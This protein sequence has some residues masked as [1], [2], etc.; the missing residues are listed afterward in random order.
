M[1]AGGGR[2][3]PAVTVAAPPTLVGRA[4]ALA[5]VTGAADAPPA[6]VVV[7]GEAGIGK[8]R[9]LA[10][11]LAARPDRT[12]LMLACPPLRDPFPLGP[13]IT[14]LH[15]F[16]QR[17]AELELTPLTG[18]LRP[19]FPDWA[20][21]LPPVPASLDSP[22]ATRHRI[23][24]ALSDLVERLGIEVLALEDAHWADS[25]TLEWLLTLT[26]GD[27]QPGDPVRGATGRALVVTYRPTDVPDGS[28]LPRLTSRSP[29]GW[30]QAVVE[31]A[32]LD[33]GQTRELVG[34]MLGAAEVSQ[35]LAAF[36][37]RHTDGLPLA[38]E[39]TVRFLRERQDLADAHGRWSRQALAQ[40]RVPPKLRDSV[41]ERVAQLE[42]DAEAVLRASAV[43]G[44]PADETLL[45]T[46]AGLDPEAGRRGI[47]RASRAGLLRDAGGG[48]LAFRHVLDAKAVEEAVPAPERW[49]LHARAARALRDLRPQPVVRLARH[50]REA[51][52]VEAWCRYAEAAA[53][54]AWESGDDHTATA[55]LMDLLGASRDL[56]ASGDGPPGPGSPPGSPP[57]A[58]PVARRARLALKLG[59]AAFFGAVALGEL[60]ERV[61]ASLR[62]VLAGDDLPAPERGEIQVQLGRMLWRVGQGRAAFAAFEAAVPDLAHRPD[63]A[64]R[65][66]SNLAVPGVPGWPVQRHLQWL[67]RA[68]E[69]ADRAG[70]RSARLALAVNR[71]TTLLLLGRE[72]GW[73]AIGELPGSATDPQEQ[74]LVASGLMNMAEGSMPWG[75]YRDTRRLLDRA[76]DFAG[77]INYQRFAETAQVLEAYLDWYTGAWTGLR[78]AAA[79]LA[80]VEAVEASYRLRAR[81]L[82]A[83]LD[84]AAGRRAA[85]EELRLVATEYARWGL[86]EPEMGLAPA[87]W[88]RQQVAGGNF[89]AVLPV[90]TPVV[91][92]VTAKEVWL[93]ATD[94]APVH[95]AALVG[96]G[97]LAPAEE[98]VERFGS[99]L[100]DGSAPAPAAA[101]ATCRALVAEGRGDLSGAAEWFARAARAW[102]ALPRPYDELLAREGQGRCLVAAGDREAGV[103][104]W[105]AAEPRLRELGARWD[106][107]RIAHQLRQQGVEVTRTWRRG[108]R[109]YGD[110]LS[111]RELQTVELVARGLTNPEV[112]ATLFLSPK[113]VEQHVR[114]AMRKLRVSSR[115]ALA[116]AA[117]SAGLLSPPPTE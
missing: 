3:G 24:R 113:T 73:E 47:V 115:T 100:P 10:E 40:L 22:R 17:V 87:G 85:A 108:P 5:V 77:K 91:E 19:L 27:P 109:G 76:S 92:L 7:E 99:G 98:L 50:L 25:A 46:V 104:V 78:Q 93:W 89:D 51:N 58:H 52:D 20:D 74:R 23:L 101:L 29:V 28:L 36:L 12:A 107:D 33:V 97:R 105:S 88:G 4:D 94:L 11:A 103:A 14:G 59:E 54:L 31:L 1:G 39:E 95:V 6:L 65:A 111:P 21:R 64:I 110:R 15:R 49:D 26:T 90:T 102:A 2:Q 30:T 8:S 72:S 96:T 9:L 106:A 71:A 114:S 62:A 86:A 16:R 42:P 83:L 79:G 112:A 18:A 48:Q 81:Q 38:L 67:S 34:S 66:M 80:T 75:R 116:M 84:L 44:E 82:V 70:S 56:G 68:Q 13:V 35:E 60:A 61:V 32:P 117:A 57:A 55:T 41:L 37:H 53:D 45:A 63:L 69:L 43:L